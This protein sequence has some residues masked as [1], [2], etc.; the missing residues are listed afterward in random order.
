MSNYRVKFHGNAKEETLQ[1]LAD[2]SQITITQFGAGYLLVKG[3]S[4]TLI[5]LL[6]VY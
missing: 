5:L 2:Q 4:P 6:M 1:D 3:E